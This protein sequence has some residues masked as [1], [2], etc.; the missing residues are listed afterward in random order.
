MPYRLRKRETVSEGCRRIILEQAASIISAL[1]DR[2]GGGLDER[3][4]DVRKRIKRLRALLR[5]LEL[6]LDDKTLE[7][8]EDTLRSTAR[9][10]AP[11][12]DASVVLAAFEEAAVEITGGAVE[13]IRELLTESVRQAKRKALGPEKLVTLAGILRTTCEALSRAGTK[14]DGWAAVGPGICESYRSARKHRRTAFSDPVPENLHR[15]RR[16]SKRLWEQLRLLRRALPKPLV[17][18]LPR[19]EK[20][21]DL[22][23][24]HHDFY[25]LQATLQEAAAHG[26]E[27]AKFPPLQK[28]VSGEMGRCLKRA[29]KLGG[30]IFA[31]RPKAF[32]AR[33]H[34]GW[35]KWRG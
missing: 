18:Q 27:V 23:G 26:L 25:T 14:D 19:L 32:A 9:K 28:F 16:F 10:L 33:L 17:K 29:R 22:L 24:R 12:R 30:L 20:F 1:S 35:K 34:A 6:K 15:C 7:Q 13:R 8:H 4:H 21:T 31:W 11:A 2:G 5:L 3:I